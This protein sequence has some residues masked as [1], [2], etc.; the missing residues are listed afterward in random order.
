MWRRV[1]C[2]I[3]SD[4][5]ICCNVPPFSSSS[6]P[7]SLLRHLKVYAIKLAAR[8]SVCVCVRLL[9]EL[10]ECTHKFPALFEGQVVPRLT[11]ALSFNCKWKVGSR[12]EEAK[13]KGKADYVEALSLA[14]GK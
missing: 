12:W 7:S 2:N 3:F 10:G 5:Y 4:I 6:S 13:E 8:L 11:N 9:T 14:S 1:S